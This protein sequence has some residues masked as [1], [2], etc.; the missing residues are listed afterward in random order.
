MVLRRRASVPLA[1]LVVEPQGS[2]LRHTA[3][4]P[5]GRPMPTTLL[6]SAQ[7]ADR[8][9]LRPASLKAMRRRKE[10]PPWVVVGNNTVRYRLSDVERFERARRVEPRQ[11]AKAGA[12]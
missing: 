12:R 6:T 5:K 8:W 7:L 10:G 9:S 1:P 4:A 2:R 3:L 11:L